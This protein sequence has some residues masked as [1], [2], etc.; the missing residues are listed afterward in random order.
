MAKKNEPKLIR[1]V[2]FGSGEN[3]I[4]GQLFSV[5]PTQST[6]VI[7]R[8]IVKEV[9]VKKTEKIATQTKEL[10]IRPAVEGLNLKNAEVEKRVKAIDNYLKKHTIQEALEE[11]GKEVIKGNKQRKKTV[12]K[13]AD[14]AKK[15]EIEAFNK[16]VEEANAKVEDT[17]ISWQPRIEKDLKIPIQKVYKNVP[18]FE[19]IET[20]EEEKEYSYKE[21]AEWDFYFKIRPR[22]AVK[23]IANYINLKKLLK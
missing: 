12:P 7:S 15:K 11:V 8:Q 22:D 9:E 17:I 21:L 16:K 10:L 19:E 23:H 13:N 6:I 4:R 18:G 5:S 20:I 14:A 3:I 1:T 2:N